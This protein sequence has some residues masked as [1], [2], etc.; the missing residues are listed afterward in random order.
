MSSRTNNAA[1]LSRQQQREDTHANRKPQHETRAGHTIPTSSNTSRSRHDILG[2]LLNAPRINLNTCHANM[3]ALE[4]ERA[5]TAS[6]ARFALGLACRSR[7]A[8]LA[9]N[10]RIKSR[11]PHPPPACRSP[12]PRANRASGTKSPHHTPRFS[13]SS[14]QPNANAQQPNK[15]RSRPTARATPAA[16]AFTRRWLTTPPTPCAPG[17][18]RTPAEITPLRLTGEIPAG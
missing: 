14:R 12:R 4:S 7:R 2:P 13:C 17:D 18:E 16:A 11:G 6:E 9:R 1:R 3:L 8:A 10:L 15:P 5:S